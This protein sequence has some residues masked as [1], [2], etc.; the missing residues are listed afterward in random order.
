MN[1]SVASV[2]VEFLIFCSAWLRI[3]KSVENKIIERNRVGKKKKD[4]C[5]NWNKVERETKWR[6][7]VKV[8]CIWF[9]RKET[10]KWFDNFF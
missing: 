10:A 1:G 5:L 9:K 4:V 8:I 3:E 6:E 7:I 2:I